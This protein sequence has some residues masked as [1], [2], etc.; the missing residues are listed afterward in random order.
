M[1]PALTW[2]VL[3]VP[4]L[5]SSITHL[6][7][8]QRQGLGKLLQLPTAQLLSERDKNKQRCFRT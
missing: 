5:S 7:Q 4:V 1:L 8:P 6:L 2:S 3:V